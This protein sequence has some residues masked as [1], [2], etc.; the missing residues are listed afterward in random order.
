MFVVTTIEDNIRVHP[1]ELSKPPLKAVSD[2][3]EKRYVD[4]VVANIG[5]VVT[6]YD[7]LDISGGFIYPNDGAAN[8]KVK[9]RV[10]VFR[11]FPGEIIVG[12]LAS[13]TK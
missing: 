10:V 8:F 4:K 2:V 9:F 12:K 1:S 3:I 6:L 11:P 5:L 7:V 13:C